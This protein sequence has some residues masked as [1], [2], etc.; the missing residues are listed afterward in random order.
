MNLIPVSVVIPTFNRENQVCSAI[1]SVLKQTVLPMEILIVDDGSTDSTISLIRNR[2]KDFLDQIRIFSLEHGGVSRARNFG[3]ERS[4]FDWIAFLDSDDLWLPDKLKVQW[5]VLQEQKDIEILQSQEIWIRN[6]KRINPPAH[7]QKS[8]GWIFDRSLEMCSI[9]PSSVLLKK[10]LYVSAGKMDEEL[11]ACEDYDLWL[12][13]TATHPVTLLDELLLVRYGGHDDQLSF[14]HPVMDR[15]R[16]Y[17]ILKILS[18]DLLNENQR[19]SSKRI[20][21]IKWN[22]LKQGKIKRNIWKNELDL[23]LE[24]VLHEG[25]NSKSGK[26]LKDFLLQDADWTRI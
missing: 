25:L 10:D 20:L 26:H 2:F 6:G 18:S 4:V 1:E 7:L 15:F 13:I 19:N 11:P 16:I 5:K 21:F 14:Q 17:S 3:V 8:N 9:T 24:I 12:R 23:D 22:L